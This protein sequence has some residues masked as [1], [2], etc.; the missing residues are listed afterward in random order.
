MNDIRSAQSAQS[1]QSVKSRCNGLGRV[2]K[3]H[4]SQKPYQN[5]FY[6]PISEQDSGS[7]IIVQMRQLFLV[8]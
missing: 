5:L 2:L 3:I 6:M 1:V 8:E 4:A 7:L